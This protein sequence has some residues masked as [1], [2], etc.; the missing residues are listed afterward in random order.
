LWLWSEGNVEK[1]A[2]NAG[3]GT[4]VMPD[5][6]TLIFTGNRAGFQTL[7]RTSLFDTTKTQPLFT[8]RLLLSSEPQAAEI[9]LG[10]HFLGRTPTTLVGLEPGLHELTLKKETYQD[11][12]L[13]LSLSSA[14]AREVKARL[15]AKGAASPLTNTSGEKTEAVFSPDGSQVAYVEGTGEEAQLTLFEM[16]SRISIP[17]GIG[18][19]PAWSANGEALYFVRGTTYSDVWVY[20][21]ASKDSIQLTH[22]GGARDP[23]PAPDG[24]WVAYLQGLDPLQL[25]LWVMNVDGKDARRLA[26]DEAG[27]IFAFQWIPDAKQIFYLS[28]HRGADVANLVDLEG[29]VKEFASAIGLS[30]P[31]WSTGNDFLALQAWSGSSSEIRIYRQPEGTFYASQE[32]STEKCTLFWQNTV[33]SWTA[34][35]AGGFRLWSWQPQNAAAPGIAVADA[36]FLSFSPILN[37]GL[38]AASWNGYSQLYLH[39]ITP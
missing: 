21:L 27:H 32:I 1:I 24:S 33:L 23:K 12:H 16:T 20:T 17:L 14:E 38:S 19:R 30:L 29:E 4:S 22:S 2:E 37:Q 34:P 13:V 26:R 6:S 39:R 18:W 11:W 8:S 36:R 10:N 7:W 28:H 31:V 35:E 25:E 9:Y 5:A 15:L 3:P